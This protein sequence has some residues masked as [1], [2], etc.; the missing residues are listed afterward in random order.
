MFKTVAFFASLALASGL[1][2][3]KDRTFYEEKFYDWLSNHEKWRPKD[4]SRFLQMLENFAQNDD[5]IETSN[6]KNLPYQLGHNEFSGMSLDEFRDYYRLDSTSVA[7]IEPAMYLYESH[8]NISAVPTS[9]DWTKKGAVTPV[10]DQGQ[11]GSC[12]AFSATGNVFTT[13]CRC[14]VAF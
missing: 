7:F 12:W 5:F 10:K 8:T 6:A 4:G 14:Y 1:A 9:V 3:L 13:L 11:C 2:L